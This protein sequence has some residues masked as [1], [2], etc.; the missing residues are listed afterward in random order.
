M[1]LI[2]TPE[3]VIKGEFLWFGLILHSDVKVRW[4]KGVKKRLLKDLR[5]IVSSTYQQCFAFHSSTQPEL[6]RKFI[7]SVGGVYNHRRRTDAGDMV[8]MYIFPRL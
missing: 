6:Q 4:S 5:L 2:E 1:I 3:Y 8:E 7:Q